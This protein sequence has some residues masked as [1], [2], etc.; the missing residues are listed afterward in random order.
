MT[1]LNQQ[2]RL[3]ARPVGMVKPTDWSLTSEPV[4]TPGPGEFVVKIT[5]LSLDPAMRGWMNEGKSYIAPVAIGAVMRAL[6]GGEVA[7][8]NNAAFPVGA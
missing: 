1:A 8:S 6:G 2:F 5:H 4:P 7:A 3:A